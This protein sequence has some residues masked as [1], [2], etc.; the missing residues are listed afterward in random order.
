MAELKEREDDEEKLLAILLLI[1]AS[2]PLPFWLSANPSPYWFL[3]KIQQAKLRKV[4]DSI[5]IRAARGMLDEI[6]VDIGDLNEA[7][8]EAN[9]ETP[10]SPTAPS[11]P[12]DL[13]GDDS[14]LA[15][16]KLRPQPVNRMRDGLLDRLRI[17]GQTYELEL[18][19][20]LS[21]IYRE[22]QNEVAERQR[23][24]EP[25]DPVIY[26]EHRARNEAVTQTTAFISQ[27]ELIT[28]AFVKGFL[29]V[30]VAAQWI[31]EIDGR[32]CPVCNSLHLAFQNVWMMRFPQ[33]SPAHVNCRCYLQFYRILG[34]QPM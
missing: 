5:S 20:R 28:A 11:T 2:E 34:N 18:A 27:G 19:N 23:L 32:Q 8:R 3:E 14:P 22:W 26:P 1:F 15:D 13:P 12:I 17:V 6:Q 25:V 7:I 4:V 33:G 31:T 30:Q 10:P 9:E 21:R 24:A 16:P 29:H